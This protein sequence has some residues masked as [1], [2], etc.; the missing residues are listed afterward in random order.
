MDLKG[1]IASLKRSSY[2]PLVAKTAFF[3]GSQNQNLNFR[4]GLGLYADLIKTG[5]QILEDQASQ[6]RYEGK[7]D[8]R[9][10]INLGSDYKL[11]DKTRFSFEFEKIFFGDL[12]VDWS[13]NAN[14]RY[15][16]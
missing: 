11:N 4:T 5:D 7:K 16:F 15:S 10:F 13:V 6:R 12:N 1:D 8:Q 2:I 3:I 9:M 14:L